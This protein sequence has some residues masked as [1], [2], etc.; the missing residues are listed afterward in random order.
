MT[1]STLQEKF[2]IRESVNFK[3]Y[4]ILLTIFTT[5]WV[6][7]NVAAIKFVTLFGCRLTG[8]LITFPLA[9][10]LN[11]IITEV[12]G[13]KNSRLAIWMGVLVNLLFVG[14][15]YLVYLLPSSHDW[16]LDSAFKS[17]LLPSLRIIIGSILAFLISEMV[18]AYLIVKMKLKFTKNHLF[19]RLLLASS[20]SFMLDITIFMMSAFYGKIH[21]DVLF[22]LIILAY[23]KKVVCQIG[24]YPL[25]Y[26]LIKRLK[27]YEKIEISDLKTNFTPFTLDHEYDIA[28]NARKKFSDNIIV[29][30]RYESY[31]KY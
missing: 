28:V 6:S 30:N 26:V 11:N 13:Y 3:I 22:H 18:N 10:V 12:Y 27:L 8:G 23:L 29:L 25:G 7:S 9:A 4:P 5:L 24:L 2:I 31:K 14:T 1:N 20:I 16:K 19:L 17:I 21:N 15:L